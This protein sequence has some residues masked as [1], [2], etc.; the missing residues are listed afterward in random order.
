MIPKSFSFSK[1]EAGKYFF[2]SFLSSLVFQNVLECESPSEVDGRCVFECSTVVSFFVLFFLLFFFSVR[3]VM[4]LET[5]TGRLVTDLMIKLSNA[6]FP[7]I[8]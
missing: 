7:T 4:Y 6:F 8:Y 5:M 3:V 1:Y 2:I